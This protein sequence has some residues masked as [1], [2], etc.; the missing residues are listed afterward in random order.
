MSPTHEARMLAYPGWPTPGHP[1]EFGVFTEHLAGTMW[2]WYFYLDD[3]NTRHS[4]PYAVEAEC[5]LDA[6]LYLEKAAAEMRYI[7]PLRP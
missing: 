3:R 4:Q 1:D 6:L 7:Y 5:R 2:L